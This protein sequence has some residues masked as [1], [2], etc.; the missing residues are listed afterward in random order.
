VGDVNVISGNAG[1]LN[2]FKHFRHGH[3]LAVPA[4]LPD[5]QRVFRTPTGKTFTIKKMSS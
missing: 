5:G 4:T 2:T 3:E 1:Q